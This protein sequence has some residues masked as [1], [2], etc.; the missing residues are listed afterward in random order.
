MRARQVLE[1]AGPAAEASSEEIRRN[2]GARASQRTGAHADGQRERVQ[3]EFLDHEISSRQ[4]GERI[5]S[6]RFSCAE[7]SLA[8]GWPSATNRTI[9]HRKHR[10]GADEV[11]LLSHLEP[12][13]GLDSITRSGLVLT[14]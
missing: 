2:A 13:P 9:R 4:V 7:T 14:G 1:L 5:K 11:R 6:E 10:T 8:G 3:L 12:L